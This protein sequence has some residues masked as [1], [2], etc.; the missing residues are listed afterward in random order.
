MRA[1]IL[2][3]YERLRHILEWQV[4]GIAPT[5]MIYQIAAHYILGPHDKIGEG[6]VVNFALADIQMAAMRTMLVRDAI[7]S[8]TLMRQPVNI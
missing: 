3:D 8:A 1:A 5:E 7:P 4:F 2:D 6:C